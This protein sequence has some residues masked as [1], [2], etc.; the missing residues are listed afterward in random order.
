[1]LMIGVRFNNRPIPLRW[2]IKTTQGPIGFEEQEK[3]LDSIAS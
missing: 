1:M 3:L 2:V